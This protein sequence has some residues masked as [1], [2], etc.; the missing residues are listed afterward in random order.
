MSST[1]NM[2]NIASSPSCSHINILSSDSGFI[3]LELLSLKQY[4]PNKFFFFFW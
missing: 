4:I 1:Q 2:K 3:V